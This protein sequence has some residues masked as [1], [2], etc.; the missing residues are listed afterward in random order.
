MLREPVGMTA[1]SAHHPRLVSVPAQKKD[2]I[3]EQF[4]SAAEFVAA[5]QIVVGGIGNEDRG[6]RFLRDRARA[7]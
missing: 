2:E 1:V 3:V 4:F 5:A 6:T 7:G